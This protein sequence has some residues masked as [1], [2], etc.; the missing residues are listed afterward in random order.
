MNKI[1]IAGAGTGSS[2]HRPAGGQ[3]PSGA[4]GRC[5]NAHALYAGPDTGSPRCGGT[6]HPS[7]THQTG[8]GNYSRQII[9]LDWWIYVIFGL[10]VWVEICSGKR[11]IK[12]CYAHCAKHR[13]RVCTGCLR[14]FLEKPTLP[15]YG[16]HFSGQ[17]TGYYVCFYL[18]CTHVLP[19]YT[20]GGS[21][22]PDGIYFFRRIRSGP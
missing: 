13:G 20:S 5:S 6:H 16:P 8:S 12:P 3:N 14:I 21:L 2:S 22:C 17:R 18:L 7:E 4:D 10:R 9:L 15:C 11:F 1:T 19:F